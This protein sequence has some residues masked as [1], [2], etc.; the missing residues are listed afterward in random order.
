[1]SRREPIRRI[2]AASAVVLVL[3]TVASCGNSRDSSQGEETVPRITP[4]SGATTLPTTT[5]ETTTTSVA[6]TNAPTA[7]PATPFP[8]SAT[9]SPT[10][11]P[12][13]PAPITSPPTQ[14]P[15]TQPPATEPP[16][17]QPPATQPLTTPPPI[18]L[19]P[20]TPAPPT[21][22]VVTP[23][24]P[25]LCT[26]AAVGAATG[27][28]TV[29]DVSCHAGWAIGHDVSCPATGE[30][31]G[32]DVFH[33]TSSGWVHDGYFPAVCAEALTASGMSIYTASSFVE[34]FCGDPPGPTEIIRPESTGE[35]VVQLQTALV[36]LGYPIASDG[37]YG[38]RTEAAVRDYQSRNGLEVDGIAG[39]QTQASLGIG[40]SGQPSGGS[41][42]TTPETAAPTT[43]P[44]ATTTPTTTTPATT[45]TV[46][47]ADDPA[48][49]SSAAVGEDI[50]RAVDEITACHA[51]WALGQV[52]SC[53][54]NSA[55]P[56]ADLFRIS[57]T[58]WAF[59]RQV[60]YQ[61][62]EDLHDAGMSAYTAAD[63]APWC[64]V[65]N[66]PPVRLVIEPGSTGVVVEQLQVALVALGYNI[67]ID[68][69]Y[70]EG[71]EQAVRD[72]QSRNGLEA[73]GIAGPETREMLGL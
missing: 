49:C 64:G 72:F 16:A 29:S 41:S 26:D 37:T 34:T 7:P 31:D 38:P 13:T 67:A 50:G 45:T 52:K 32:V 71:T 5:A 56:K 61:C 65:P 59:I 25:T 2:G 22:V 40:P 8:T 10:Q 57:E 1:M 21:T 43:A 24:E 20:G 6:P 60:R 19:P 54:A 69:T 39:P 33:V 15:A 70:G 68:A 28:L 9:A 11:P 30:C 51:G 36:A 48:E 47:G 12:T 55:C 17:T 35:R 44:P 14:P 63:F 3:A 23:G 66:L 27:L 4:T 58:G 62:A 42:T 73:D 53:P 46:V 18:T